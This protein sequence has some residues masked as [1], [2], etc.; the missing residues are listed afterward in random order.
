[1]ILNQFLIDKWFILSYNA[2]VRRRVN[3]SLEMIDRI[4]CQ[5]ERPGAYPVFF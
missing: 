2:S 3:H 4:R 5:A 1:M